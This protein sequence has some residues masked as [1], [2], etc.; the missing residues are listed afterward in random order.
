MICKAKKYVNKTAET[1][2]CTN[3]VDYGYLCRVHARQISEA[4][5]GFGVSKIKR[6]HLPSVTDREIEE[7]VTLYRAVKGVVVL[8]S[9]DPMTFLTSVLDFVGE[10]RH[11]TSGQIVNHVQGLSGGEG[12]TASKVGAVLRVL[13]AQGK[14]A[15]RLTTEKNMMGRVKGSACYEL[16]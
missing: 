14:I 6:I 13:K 15:R 1:T 8:K 11:V 16:L 9:R 5:S 7:S 2:A 12:M 3:P 4:S 10:N